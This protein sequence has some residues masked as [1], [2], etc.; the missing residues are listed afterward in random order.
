MTIKCN[1]GKPLFELGCIVLYKEQPYV[2]ISS[3][4]NFGSL[5]YRYE[6]IPYDEQRL[7]FAH[8]ADLL[9]SD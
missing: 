1:Y 5:C 9:E 8:E 6:L 3:E 4:Y 2:V 7:E